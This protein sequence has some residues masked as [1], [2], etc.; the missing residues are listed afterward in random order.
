MTV[1]ALF[2]NR[3]NS[4][5]GASKLDMRASACSCTQIVLVNACYTNAVSPQCFT[6]TRDGRTFKPCFIL[7]GKVGVCE[8]MGGGR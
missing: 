2:T 8:R 4:F 1:L 5:R 7:G 6:S 3:T